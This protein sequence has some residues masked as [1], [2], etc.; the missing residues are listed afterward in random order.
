MSFDELSDASDMSSVL[1]PVLEGTFPRKD[2]FWEE[3]TSEKDGVN[4]G[5]A[6]FEAVCESHDNNPVSIMAGEGD[7]EVTMEGVS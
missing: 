3:E 1:R 5:P 2:T 6:K 4:V 7:A